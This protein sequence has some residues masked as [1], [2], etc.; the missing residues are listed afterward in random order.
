MGASSESS[1]GA[2]GGS[3]G[4]AYRN[5][6]V[7]VG[8]GKQEFGRC[9]MGKVSDCSRN[10]IASPGVF[11]RHSD[12]HRDAQVARLTDLGQSAEFT[13]LKIDYIHGQIASAAKESFKSI[14][15][16]IEHKR[17]VCLSSDCEAFLVTYARLFDINIEVLDSSADAYGFV[18]CPTGIGIGDESIGRMQCC[19]HRVDSFDIDIGIA[20][21]F[22]LE[23]SVALSS[24]VG[25]IR[26][27]LF[28]RL[29]GDRAVEMEIIA[30]ATA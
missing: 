26:G 7:E 28:R 12:S 14:N 3:V 21:D 13:D 9:A 19:A 25:D 22:E 30:V 8:T 17:V 15:I 16:F 2:L 11:D 6:A 24:V 29:L 5:I 10:D 23:P 1:I 18:L 20:A 27:H 4:D